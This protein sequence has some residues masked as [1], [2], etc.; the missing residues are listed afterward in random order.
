MKPS[1]LVIDSIQT[2]YISGVDS[3]MG[4]PAQ[5]R[6]CTSAL[7]RF[8]KKTNISVMIVG[9][10]TKEGNLAGPAFWSIWWTWFSTWKGIGAISSGCSA[11]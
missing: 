4:S 7:V 2:M 3:P 1:M 8:A 6:D 11:L 10:V 9:H 5:I